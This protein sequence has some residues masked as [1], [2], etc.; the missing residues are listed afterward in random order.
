M[1][2]P[3]MIPIFYEHVFCKIDEKPFAVL[4]SDMGSPNF[5][6]N[7]LLSLEL[8]KHMRNISDDDLIDSFYFD[9]LVNYAVG[10]RTLG[11]LNLAEKTL[12]NFRS[13]IYSYLLEHPKEE[14]LIFGQ[15]INLTQNFAKIA[16]ISLTEQRMDT[17]MFM[18]NIKKAGRLTLSFDV[19][20]MAIKAIP[21]E[22]RTA[23]LAEVLKDGFKTELLYKSKP[24]EGDSRLEVMLN[25]GKTALEILESIPEL[26]ESKELR[27]LNRLLSEQAY[28]DEETNC[29]KAKPNKTIPA[30]SLQ[31]AYDEDATF[32]K[33]S[34]AKA[35]SGYVLSIAETCSEENKFQ[36]ITDYQVDVNNKSDIEIIGERLPEI[37]NNTECDHMYV[38]GGFYS[39]KT[40]KTG[41]EHGTDIHY[42]N[43]T[44]ARPH[45]KLPVTDFDIDEAT[46]TILKCPNGKVPT[47]TYVRKGQ[48][49]A[50]YPLDVCKNCE[51]KDQCY[52]KQQKKSAI[53]R[54]SLKAIRTGKQRDNIF[55]S[56]KHRVESNVVTCEHLKLTICCLACIHRIAHTASSIKV[57][58]FFCNKSF[59]NTT[60]KSSFISVD[61]HLPALKR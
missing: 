51:F 6:V 16:G 1:K 32:R 54:I 43:L 31:S 18:S 2:S 36:L 57:Q 17:T 8:V 26:H 28:M 13:R 41:E 34:S 49:A 55:Y 7:I 46:N 44:G 39:E 27:I 25:L 11:E 3:W 12:Y 24:S 35:Q 9:Y 23:E 48:T 52:S 56:T 21:E 42:T 29:L 15:F 50:H 60:L 30:D 5:P 33:K 53:V 19:L 45:K 10:I 4:Y 38:D 37:S 61:R 59:C 47:S 20:Y 40:T 22:K 14:D 58:R